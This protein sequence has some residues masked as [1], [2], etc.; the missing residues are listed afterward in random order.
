MLNCESIAFL[1]NLGSLTNCLS[2]WSFQLPWYK[3][4]SE[5]HL[6]FYGGCPRY[7]L[8]LR[9]VLL[10]KQWLARGLCHT[11]HFCYGSL[12]RIGYFTAG[13]SLQQCSLPNYEKT[14]LVLYGFV[15]AARDKVDNYVGAPFLPCTDYEDVRQ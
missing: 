6:S 7:P 4:V 8:R 15:E 13:A 10:H 14:P 5:T 2:F 11:D 3:V 1:C 9:K 12:I